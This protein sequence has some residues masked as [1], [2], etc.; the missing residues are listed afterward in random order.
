GVRNQPFLSAE[1]LE[2]LAYAARQARARG[3]TLDVTLGTG[4]PYGGPWVT[5]NYAARMIRERSNK[6]ALRPGEEVVARVGD[7]VIVS[8]PT[9]MRVKRAAL[10][11]E[12]FVLDPF[13]GQA[14]QHHLQMA[15]EKL[16]QA[17]RGAGVRAYWCDSLEVYDANWTADFPEQFRRLR[18]YDL[19]P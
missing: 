7:N 13:N 10:G 14:L 8:M 6:D 3:L 16:H 5:P 12:G 1:F 17:L 18:G 19:T 2:M 4:W 9:G 11:G 15:G